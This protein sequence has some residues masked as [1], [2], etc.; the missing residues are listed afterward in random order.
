M[1]H[2]NR[3]KP[4]I[5]PE[6]RPTNI[7]EMFR[8]TQHEMNPEEI[9]EDQL[10]QE[11]DNAAQEAT[12]RGTQQVTQQR[13][14][15]SQNIDKLIKTANIRGVRHYLVRWKGQGKDRP[16]NTW[17]P[18]TKI[19]DLLLRD[20]HIHKTLQGYKRKRPFLPHAFRSDMT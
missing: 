14:T 4:F 8:E 2:A 17:E 3:L 13:I 11:D 1:I 9:P 7:P 15:E 6:L 19:P 20:Y 16:K 5:D 12:D 10:H 18:S